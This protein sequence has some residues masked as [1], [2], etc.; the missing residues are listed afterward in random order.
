MEEK[1]CC[2]FYNT[3]A[4]SAKN[5]TG[6][7]RTD[8]P[9]LSRRAELQLVLRLSKLGYTQNITQNSAFKSGT[10]TVCYFE[11]TVESVQNLGR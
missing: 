11:Q 4:N 5:R 10:L 3:D 7:I 2:V 8:L 1:K 6:K 9:S